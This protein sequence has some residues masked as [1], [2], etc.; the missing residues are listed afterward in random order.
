MMGGAIERTTA[1]DRKS[2]CCEVCNAI[3]Y[4]RHFG[5]NA[6]AACA[7]FF[8]RAVVRQRAVQKKARKKAYVCRGGGNCDISDCGRQVLAGMG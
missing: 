4:T 5:V 1:V 7:A 3:A 8:R 2:L 6:C